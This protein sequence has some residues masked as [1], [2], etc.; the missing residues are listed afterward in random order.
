MPSCADM[1]NNCVYPFSPSIVS[2][3]SFKVM[4]SV[5]LS[6][7]YIYIQFIYIKKYIYLSRKQHLHLNL[8]SFHPK[9]SLFALTTLLSF[10]FFFLFPL[11]FISSCSVSVI[12]WFSAPN[13]MSGNEV[14]HRSAFCLSWSINSILGI[15]LISLPK[16]ECFWTQ[17]WRWISSSFIS[18]FIHQGLS[19][20]GGGF[21]ITA[22]PSADQ[23]PDQQLFTRNYE[24]GRKHSWERTAH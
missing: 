5:H 1:S 12:P 13:L 15:C 19:W 10:L 2:P 14:H 17:Q 9:T 3:P 21:V 16:H 11:F 20:K 23:G 7:K 24:L 22:I 8:K 4:H 18:I 6:C